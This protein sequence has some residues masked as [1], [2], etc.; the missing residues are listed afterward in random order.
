MSDV[1]C[2]VVEGHLRYLEERG[3]SLDALRKALPIYEAGGRVIDE[4]LLRD[5]RQHIEWDTYVQVFNLAGSLRS[6]D[7]QDEFVRQ[8]ISICLLPTIPD[9]LSLPVA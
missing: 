1:S 8:G 4:K 6:E 7:E 5:V 3:I 2:R 9:G